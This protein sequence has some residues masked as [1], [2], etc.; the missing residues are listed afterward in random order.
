MKRAHTHT[1]FE[2]IIVN[3]SMLEVLIQKIVFTMINSRNE[4]EQIESTVKKYR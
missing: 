1:Q 3:V 4:I 2:F